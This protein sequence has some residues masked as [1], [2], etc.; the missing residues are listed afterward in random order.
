MLLKRNLDIRFIPRQV[1]YFRVICGAAWCY[2]VLQQ[3][4]GQKVVYQS[5][6]TNIGG[7][8]DQSAFLHIYDRQE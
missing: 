7:D 6:A 8:C 2:P 1:W 5:G 4:G 3:S